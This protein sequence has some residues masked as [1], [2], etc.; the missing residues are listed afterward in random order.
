M[1]EP[2][3]KSQWRLRGVFIALIFAFALFG[4]IIPLHPP[5]PGPVKTSQIEQQQSAP[6]DSNP[7]TAN[8]HAQPKMAMVDESESTLN[9]WQHDNQPNE[10]DGQSPMSDLSNILIAG[11]TGALV[12]VAVFQWRSMR[13]QAGYMRDG[14]A[15]TKLAA[16]S[17]TKSAEIAK[18]T[19]ER[20]VIEKRIEQRPWLSMIAPRPGFKPGEPPKFSVTIKN[21]GLTPGKVVRS[22][23]DFA[24]V[25]E[26]TDDEIS[27]LI[28]N[29]DRAMAGGMC[30]VVAPGGE[31]EFHGNYTQEIGKGIYDKITGR[32]LVAFFIMR[33]EYTGPGQMT[34][35]TQLCA[36]YDAGAQRIVAL[37]RGNDMT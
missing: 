30:G 6:S 29:V 17:A 14:L 13:A 23:T 2:L 27:R 8:D 7:T 4:A 9:K 33:I 22:G 20:S 24:I 1:V 31:M 25:T 3:T 11:F 35:M 5:A 32:E 26:L 10:K 16:D 19:L 12:L 21:S 34:G 15:V 36:A 18:E 28:K 37:Q